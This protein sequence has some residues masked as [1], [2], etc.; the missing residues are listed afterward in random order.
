MALLETT[1]QPLASSPVDLATLVNSP[2][3][4][5]GEWVYCENTG[6]DDL[7]FKEGGTEPALTDKGHSLG[8][9]DAVVLLIASRPLWLWS[10]AA[11][12]EATL[13]DAAP[14]PARGA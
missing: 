14:A 8:T 12:G 11:D 3:G 5:V 2:V 6:S 4:A 9:G 1:V 10:P 7:K 13:S